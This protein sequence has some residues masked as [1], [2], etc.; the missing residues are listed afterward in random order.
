MV[1][2]TVSPLFRSVVY[3][4]PVCRAGASVSTRTRFASVNIFITLFNSGDEQEEED[5][6]EDE[7][8]GEDEE[9]T[10]GSEQE[11][12]V[13]E[14]RKGETSDEN[15]PE[16]KAEEPGAQESNGKMKIKAD[17]HINDSTGM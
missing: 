7:E 5:E 16:Q 14:D 12:E 9:E 11:E 10:E 6:E 4:L 17:I 1:N 8:D 13:G 3:L 15:V 2:C